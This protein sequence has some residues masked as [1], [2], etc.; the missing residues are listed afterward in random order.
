MLSGWT[1]TGHAS[2]LDSLPVAFAL[3]DFSVQ[4]DGCLRIDEGCHPPRMTWSPNRHIGFTFL[5]QDHEMVEETIRSMER[6]NAEAV[7]MGGA[8]N[9]PFDAANL[10]GIGD[11]LDVGPNEEA[12]PA[13]TKFDAYMPRLRFLRDEAVHD[14]Y[15]LNLAS[16]IDFRNF[17]R[18]TPDI[19]KG[20]LVLI[21][22]GNLRAI[23][24]D[25]HGTRLGIQFLG[26]RMVQFV[27]FKR[28]KQGQ[29]IS[30]VSGRDSL[31]GLERQIVAFELN[32]LLYA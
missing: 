26:G 14:G 11:E 6:F 30:R 12:R 1:D 19:R 21:D 15:V 24:K 10:E 20:N 17:V 31:E 4:G 29:S 3:K 16:E 8:S 9:P 18:S 22:N 2:R 5:S 27:I 28:R 23:W 13:P 25:E 7:A 32:S